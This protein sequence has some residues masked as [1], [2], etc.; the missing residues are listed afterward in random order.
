MRPAHEPES[1]EQDYVRISVSDE[2]DG[3]AEEDLPN[4]FEPFFTTK[5]V[6]EGTGLG[7]SITYNIVQ[8][9][10]GWIDVSSQT[11]RGSRFDIFVPK[12]QPQCEEES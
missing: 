12:D 4:I 8:E 9:H 7:L 2:G 10:G 6:G 5:D 1:T 3:I 11:G